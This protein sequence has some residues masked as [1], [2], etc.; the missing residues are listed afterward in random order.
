M[1]VLRR[2]S[3]LW[4]K[5][6]ESWALPPSKTAKTVVDEVL[7]MAKAD[8]ELAASGPKTSSVL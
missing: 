3:E 7:T 4:V 2:W 1:L 8:V 5:V 6:P